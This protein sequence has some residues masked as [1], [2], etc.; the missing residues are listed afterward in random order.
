MRLASR[1]T[2]MKV[3]TLLINRNLRDW[4]LIMRRPMNRTS[5]RIETRTDGIQRVTRDVDPYADPT[6][7]QE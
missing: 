2:P 6:D 4:L 3:A 7:T 5:E 1:T